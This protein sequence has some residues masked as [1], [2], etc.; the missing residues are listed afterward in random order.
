MKAGSQRDERCLLHN[1]A[2]HRFSR[3]ADEDTRL[4]ARP[5]MFEKHFPGLDAKMC[6]A[7][8][9]VSKDPYIRF[10]ESVIDFFVILLLET[11]SSLR[12]DYGNH[13]IV[14]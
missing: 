13:Q 11:F 14:T 10:I 3:E 8:F 6:P 5:V 2:R 9:S 4:Y 7:F 12:I 1:R